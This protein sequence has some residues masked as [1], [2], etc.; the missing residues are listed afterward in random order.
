MLLFILMCLYC[1]ILRCLKSHLE[2]KNRLSSHCICTYIFIC[3][4]IYI[5]TYLKAG[6]IDFRGISYQVIRIAAKA[7]IC[8]DNDEVR[9]VEKVA[10][11]C[12]D[13]Y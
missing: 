10:H 6:P 4:H 7:D 9:E 1:F 11:N 3:V 12:P 5:L 2:R 8:C 13:G